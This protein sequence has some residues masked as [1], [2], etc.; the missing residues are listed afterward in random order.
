MDAVV[1][2][3]NMHSNIRI[4]QSAL[5][6]IRKNINEPYKRAKIILPILDNDDWFG[7][8]NNSDFKKVKE[9][10]Y[11]MGLE[12]ESITQKVKV[13]NIIDI[14]NKY[15]LNGE[16]IFAE[17]EKDIDNQIILKNRSLAQSLNI[18]GTPALIIND[19]LSPGY[20]KYEN[21]ITILE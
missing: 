3:E 12:D 10:I 11:H 6:P 9:V 14:L 8:N 2:A 16:T 19:N 17:A 5:R 13:V 1:F 4:V 7:N 21:L 15:E 18:R 20:L